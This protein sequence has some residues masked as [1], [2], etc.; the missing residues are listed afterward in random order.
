MANFS[1]EIAD[2]DVSRVLD[3]MAANYRWS[4]EVSN[5]S[6]VEGG[7]EPELIPNPESKAMFANLMVRRFLSE[8]V[9]SYETAKAQ[10]QASE[11]LDT[12]ISTNDPQV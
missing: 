1:I 8:N 10:Q 12:S 2:E 9:T 5:P 11:N 4:A 7:A 6:Y 3:A